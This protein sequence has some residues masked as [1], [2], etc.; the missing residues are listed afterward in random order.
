MMWV[1]GGGL[2]VILLPLNH[3]E[4]VGA[5]A[6]LVTRFYIRAG[7]PAGPCVRTRDIY[8]DEHSQ[9]MLLLASTSRRLSQSLLDSLPDSLRFCRR[10]TQFPHG[11]RDSL[12]GMVFASKSSGRDELE[13]ELPLRSRVDVPSVVVTHGSV[14]ASVQ[15]TALWTFSSPCPP[16]CPYEVL[17]KA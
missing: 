2:R 6:W 4:P 3:K 7:T 9:V 15:V 10:Q 17:P 13:Q 14:S 5:A 8:P 12:H 11:A 1:S 16:S